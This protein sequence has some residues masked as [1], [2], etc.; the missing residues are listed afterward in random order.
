VETSEDGTNDA[1]NSADEEEDEDIEA[2][3][4]KEVEG[5]KP[6]AT[7]SPQ[8]RAIRIDMPCGAS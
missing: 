2:Q 8:F 1:N 5:L 7:K 3:I 4:R 6:G